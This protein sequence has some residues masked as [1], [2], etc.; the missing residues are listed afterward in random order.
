M[1]QFTT[2]SSQPR[3][4]KS[5][6]TIDGYDM[7]D[8]AFDP[9]MRYEE[10]HT[11]T[12]W[13][14]SEKGWRA[15]SAPQLWPQELRSALMPPRPPRSQLGCLGDEEEE[16]PFAEERGTLTGTIKSMNK[17][18]KF[19]IPISKLPP[20]GGLDPRRD[21]AKK[22]P[23]CAPNLNVPRAHRIVQR[24]QSM[25][26]LRSQLPAES[27]Q[28]IEAAM[29]RDRPA[30]VR[31]LDRQ[32]QRLEKPV[33]WQSNRNSGRGQKQLSSREDTDA[34]LCS[35]YHESEGS[36][37]REHPHIPCACCDHKVEK[38]WMQP[39]AAENPSRSPDGG[40]GGRKSSPPAG[41]KVRGHAAPGSGSQA[42]ESS[43]ST[44]GRGRTPGSAAGS[45]RPR[46]TVSFEE[47]HHAC[48]SHSGGREVVNFQE[49]PSPSECSSERSENWNS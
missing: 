43:P 19:Y 7:L 15:A 45:V 33:V 2:T 20:L 39:K 49:L 40:P 11:R 48:A 12:P 5:H 38:S 14:T 36:A 34:R 47:P 4:K 35:A 1:N 37:R 24:W 17:I 26:R 16:D 10:V 46:S 22:P 27:L 21:M 8:T 9:T 32:K 6:I 18:N 31:W 13:T 44:S 29:K 25:P 28:V 42:Q 30:S 23:S 3:V 41:H